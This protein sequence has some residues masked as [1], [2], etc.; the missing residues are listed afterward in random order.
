[1]RV[2]DTIGVGAGIEGVGTFIAE[3]GM[4]VGNYIKTTTDCVEILGAVKP[5]I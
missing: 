3:R 1:V 2:R 4:A 5:T